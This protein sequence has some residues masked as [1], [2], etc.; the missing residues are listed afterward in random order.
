MNTMLKPRTNFIQA[1]EPSTPSV[2]GSNPQ[3]LRL[4][5][6]QGFL[7]SSIRAMG[8]SVF[9]PLTRTPLERIEVIADLSGNGPHSRQDIDATAHHLRSTSEPS[10]VVEYSSKEIARLFGRAYQA[11]AIQFESAEFTYLLVKDAM[12]SYIYRWP[13]VDTLSLSAR[14]GMDKNHDRL[15]VPDPRASQRL[16]LESD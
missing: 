1:K 7:W 2:V 4:N 10:T 8:E 16:L 5:Q 3:W 9:S 14:I 12:G 6:L 13:G 11:Q 15:G